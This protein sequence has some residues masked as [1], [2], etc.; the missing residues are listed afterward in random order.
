MLKGSENMAVA[1]QTLVYQIIS[2]EKQKRQN[3]IEGFFV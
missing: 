1:L 2:D 3:N